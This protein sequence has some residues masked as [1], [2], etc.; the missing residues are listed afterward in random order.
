ML[1]D[2]LPR[3]LAGYAG[4]FD[5]LYANVLGGLASDS[6]DEHAERGVAAS[7]AMP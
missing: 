7:I 5:N 1:D 4:R 3:S 6:T 2:P